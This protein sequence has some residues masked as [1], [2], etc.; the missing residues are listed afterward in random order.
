MPVRFEFWDGSGSGP[1]DGIGTIT[2]RSVDALRRILWAP[3]ELGVARAF[4]AGDLDRRRRS[5]RAAAH[6]QPG[7]G[8]RPAQAGDA[9]P[10]HRGGRRRPPGRARAAAAATAR[11]V[12][13]RRAGST[14]SPA[15]PRSSAT[16]TTWA[17]TSTGWCSGPSMTYSCARFVT[18]DDHA[19]G[20]PGGQAR[21]D[22]PQ[23]RARPAAGGPTARRGLR[24]GLHGHPRR[25]SP[26]RHGGRGGP[27]PRAGRRGPTPG[28]PGRA[29][30]SD[31]DPAA[32]LPRPAA[33][34]SSTPSPR[35]ACSNMWDPA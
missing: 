35:S 5:L 15:T 32:G 7:L 9:D 28:R 12:P 8:P 34:S 10:A 18:A 17:T 31:R 14:P 23:A 24:M 6:P 25:P 2:I 29:G 1:T 21:T 4:V 11:G 20:G 13:A 33:A 27:Q 19:R 16:T 30:R 3:G 26:P 22:L